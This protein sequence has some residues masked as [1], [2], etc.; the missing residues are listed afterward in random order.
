MN[1]A[2]HSLFSS[3][4][5]AQDLHGLVLNLRLEGFQVFSII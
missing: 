5:C 1:I 4:G 2:F 3:S